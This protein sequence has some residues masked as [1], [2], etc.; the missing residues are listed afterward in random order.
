M[1]IPSLSC[2]IIRNDLIGKSQRK[3]ASMADYKIMKDYN[4]IYNTIPC[5]N[6]YI[7]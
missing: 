3:I 1:G 4:S 2:V 5:F 6:V 7:T